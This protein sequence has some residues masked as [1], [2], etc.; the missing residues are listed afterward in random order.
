MFGFINRKATVIG[1]SLI[2]GGLFFWN[3]G[4]T[5][6]PKRGS[7]SSTYVPY[8]AM[9]TIQS[10]SFS[11]DANTIRFDHLFGRKVSSTVY[12]D[13]MLRI[14]MY[15]VPTVISM[16]RWI[17]PV[18]GSHLSP[19]VLPTTTGMDT[20]QFASQFNWNALNDYV[21]FDFSAAS[22]N[23]TVLAPTQK[24]AYLISNT[25]A[26]YGVGATPTE[27][28]DSSSSSFQIT[29]ATNVK[30]FCFER[31]GK[32][33]STTVVWQTPCTRVRCNCVTTSG[34]ACL[35]GGC[36]NGKACDTAP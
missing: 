31:R 22:G 11:D 1:W 4:Y 35:M 25:T 13:W 21:F 15:G 12:R 33:S 17:V 8:A 7:G 16:D 27:V 34:S 19:Y 5:G 28:A 18:K 30:Y 36:D 20:G 3:V 23:K 32:N 26:C 9:E 2:L 6:S 10:M 29:S 24:T 14:F